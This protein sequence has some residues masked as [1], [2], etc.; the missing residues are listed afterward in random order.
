MDCRILLPQAKQPFTRNALFTRSI[1]HK[2]IS[3]YLSCS[4]YLNSYVCSTSDRKRGFGAQPVKKRKVIRLNVPK[5]DK[6]ASSLPRKLSSRQ[7]ETSIGQAPGLSSSN[8]RRSE[9]IVLDSKFNE[10]LEA[11]KRNTLE[12]R[13]AKE[14]E[15]YRAID[16]DAPIEPDKSSTGLGVKVGVG[17]AVVALGLAFTLGDFFPSGSLSTSS[18]LS[19]E[20]KKLPEEEKK[21]LQGSAVTLVELGDYK[22]AAF[23][24]EKLTKEKQKDSDVFRLLGEVKYELKDY[25]G[26]VAAYKNSISLSGMDNFEILLG[27]VNALLAA[28]K[29]DEA[30]QVLLDVREKLN[31]SEKRPDVLVEAT[32][33]SM[34][35]FDPIQIDLLLG[36]AFSSWGH[37]SDAVSVYDQIISTYPDDFRGYL[38]KG[39][40]LKENGKVGDAE[41]MFIQARFFA[42]DKAKVLV[43]QYSRR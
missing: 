20:R 19:I 11:I 43:D 35:K 28:E 14:N 38:A 6:D 22:R 1:G 9:N 10:K 25:S 37:V 23:L 36:K 34:Q 5:E 27:L 33:R 4:R 12:Q 29:P 3:A 39:V 41:R 42:P 16:Y 30:V 40:I 18:D 31:E 7:S 17:V 8:D 21:A 13:K 24:L 2:K 15:Q 26:S 32:G